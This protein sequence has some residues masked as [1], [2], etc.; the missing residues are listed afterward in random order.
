MSLDDCSQQANELSCSSY[1]E[2]HL[3]IWAVTRSSRYSPFYKH[4]VLSR[5]MWV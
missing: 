2:R 4:G 5:N 1:C 3:P